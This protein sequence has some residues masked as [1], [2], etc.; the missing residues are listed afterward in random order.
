MCTS[1]NPP[2]MGSPPRVRGTHRDDQRQQRHTGLTP[3]G[4]GNATTELWP[5]VPTGAHPRGCGEHSSDGPSLPEQ[6]R[7]AHPRG[8]GEHRR[9]PEPARTDRVGLTPAGAGNTTPTGMRGRQGWAHPRGCGEHDQHPHGSSCGAGSPPRVRGTHQQGLRHDRRTGLTPAG[10]GNTT[11][12]QR[13]TLQAVERRL[14]VGLTPAGAGNTPAGSPRTVD[15]DVSPPRVRGT[16]AELRAAGCDHGLTPAGAGNTTRPA[17]TCFK[18]GAHPRGCG[19]HSVTDR[20][21]EVFVGSPPR[22]R[23]TRHRRPPRS[24]PLRLTPA[25]AGNTTRSRGSWLTAGAHPRGCG[26]HTRRTVPPPSVGGSP[27][28]VRGTR[29]AAVDRRAGAGLTPAG[30]GNTLKPPT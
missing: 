3:A 30:A 9:S 19:E 5:S 28:R 24:R 11:I 12:S 2:L 7:R 6:T 17:M 16:R 26:E 4:A 29:A 15:P 18:S 27:P 25:G 10:A 22:V 1:P 20:M 23:G 8:C 21:E 13:L 14:R